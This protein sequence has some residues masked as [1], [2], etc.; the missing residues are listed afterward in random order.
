MT[1]AHVNLADATKESAPAML[2]AAPVP[3]REEEIARAIA[4]SYGVDP[5]D[6][7]PLSVLCTAESTPLPWWEAYVEQTNAVLTLFAAQPASDDALAKTTADRDNSNRLPDDCRHERNVLQRIGAERADALTTALA[8][9]DAL[10]EVLKPFA[11]EVHPD[12]TDSE[13]L[14][15]YFQAGDVRRARALASKEPSHDL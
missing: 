2:K 10:R 14:R 6:A 1:S 3:G 5:A 8:E 4:L 13:P 12:H 7:A 15:I 11:V 9:R